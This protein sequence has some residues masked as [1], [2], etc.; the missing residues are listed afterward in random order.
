MDANPKR[1]EA[2]IFYRRLKGVVLELEN[3]S[4]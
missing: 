4:D 2:I 1:E 3:V